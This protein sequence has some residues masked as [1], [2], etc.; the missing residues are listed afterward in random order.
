MFLREIKSTPIRADIDEKVLEY[1]VIEVVIL[2]FFVSGWQICVMY[3]GKNLTVHDH[4]ASVRAKHSDRHL[5]RR[6]YVIERF[7]KALFL[8]VDTSN[9]FLELTNGNRNANLQLSTRMA[10]NREQ[11]LQQL[12]ISSA[13]DAKYIID[14]HRKC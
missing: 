2:D 14:V 5:K 6:G 11:D 9:S 12:N 1:V 7:Y 8:Y 13:P 3:A 10:S 4:R